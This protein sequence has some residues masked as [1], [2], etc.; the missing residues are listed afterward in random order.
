MNA[1][2]FESLFNQCLEADVHRCF[3]KQLSLK[4]CKIHRKSMC[5]SLP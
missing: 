5:W 4:V 1:P 3:L 2:E